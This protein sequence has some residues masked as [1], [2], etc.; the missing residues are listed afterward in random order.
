[1][2]HKETSSKTTPAETAAVPMDRPTR[3]WRLLLLAAVVATAVVLILTVDVKAQLGGIL[4]W[5]ENTRESFGLLAFILV[6]V[7]VYILACV[8]F[9][10]G[11]IITLGAGAIVGVAWGTVAV[12]I[13]STLGASAAFFI[14]RTIGRGWIAAKLA[15]RPRFKQ[16]DE[17]VGQQGF[18]IVLLTRLSPLFPF[19]FLNFA[20]GTTKVR[21]RDY[22]LASF[23]GMLP[24]TVMFVYVGSTIKDIA[25]VLSGAGDIERGPGQLALFYGGL[26]AAVV[27]AVIITRIARTALSQ[28][29]SADE[30]Q[31]E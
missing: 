24:G 31:Q 28:T 6:F 8:L 11:S 15:G 19:N 9:V 22:L 26:V 3:A 18:K 13:G 5:M 29:I 27:V 23:L 7:G 16:I 30:H 20:Y 1:M 2:N 25:R 12:S 17:A 14:G 10:P 4:E 21:F